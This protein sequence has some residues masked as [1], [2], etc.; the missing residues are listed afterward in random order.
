MKSKTS[1]INKTILEKN[2]K[3]YW[4]IWVLYLVVIL[5]QGP[6]TMWS[7]YRSAEYYYGD[8][9]KNYELDIMSST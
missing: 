4:P 2:I 5:L 9:W 7:R 8:N 6:F 3:L 1:F